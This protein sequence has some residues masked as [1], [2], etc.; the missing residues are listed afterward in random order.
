ML[1]GPSVVPICVS[2]LAHDYIFSC[3][4][5]PKPIQYELCPKEAI[6]FDYTNNVICVLEYYVI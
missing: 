1:L 2:I 5:N 3:G 6:P 4:E